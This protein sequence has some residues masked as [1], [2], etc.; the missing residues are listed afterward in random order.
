M[1]D[2]PTVVALVVRAR[3]GDK[4]AWDQIVE[5]YAPLVWS[6]CRRHRLPEADAEDVGQTVWMRL[7]EQLA[8]I[9]QPAA[10]PGWIATTTRR[11]CLT[12]L[13]LQQNRA[14]LAAKANGD[15]TVAQTAP[16]AEGA[17]LTAERNAALRAALAQLPEPCRQ[18]LALL[19]QD[20]PLSYAEISGRLGMSIG[21]LGPR[22]AR[23]VRKLRDWPP[24]A[25]LIGTSTRSWKGGEEHEQPMVER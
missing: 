4:A 14:N 12:A 13:R 7:V 15:P 11:E 2:D 16:S 1:L 6:V 9:R 3:A 24:L 10:L 17:V 5:R 22:R 19:A 25:A 18:L 23:C 21:G 20:P 8:V